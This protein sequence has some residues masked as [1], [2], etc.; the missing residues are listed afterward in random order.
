MVIFHTA[1]G[2]KQTE[3]HK[4]NI[5]SEPKDIVASYGPGKI[6]RKIIQDGKGNIWMASW[7]GQK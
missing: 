2:Q 1:C 4:D 5:Y 6:V 3:P 7:E